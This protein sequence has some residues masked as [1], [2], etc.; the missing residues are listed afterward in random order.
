MSDYEPTDVSISP[1]ETSYFSTPSE[2]LDPKLFDGMV[3]KPWVRSAVLKFLFD[4]L[5]SN[6]Q[7]PHRWV[8]AWIAG[9]GV[10][11]QWE[12]SRDP[13]DLDCLVGINYGVFR[14]YNS[15]YN[16]LSDEEIASMLNEQFS[17]DIMP[18]TKNWE[19]Y[20]LTY[21]VNQQS[22]IQDINPYAAYDLIND[23]WTV[24]PSKNQNPPYSRIWEQRVLKDHETGT[25]LISRYNKASQQAQASVNNQAAFVN[26]KRRLDMA[27]DQASEFYEEIHK[28]RKVAFSK[29][30]AGYADFNNYRWQHGKK[31]GVI[32]ALRE[33]KDHRDRSK[34]QS[35]LDTYGTELPNTKTLIRRAATYR[36]GR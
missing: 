13:G 21:Y 26:A 10:S 23:D 18:N 17:R 6:Y 33:I 22:D 30:G 32:Q 24:A 4:N 3:L 36:A 19:G 7:D 20:E 34:T 25:E 29:T 16:G 1:S 35:D 27:M 11:Y 31:S 2:G 28:G 12:A 8:S 15:E 14:R 9:S 5:A